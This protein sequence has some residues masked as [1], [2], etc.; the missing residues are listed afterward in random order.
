MAYSIVDDPNAVFIG[1]GQPRTRKQAFELRRLGL[2]PHR[3]YVR[4]RAHYDSLRTNKII[5]HLVFDITTRAVRDSV[6]L[7]L[8]YPRP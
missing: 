1:I 8:A 4:N 3:Q 2:A 7:A 6:K 5:G